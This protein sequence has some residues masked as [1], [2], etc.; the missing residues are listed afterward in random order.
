M[1][2]NV[3]KTNSVFRNSF[4]QH[5]S[6]YK[7]HPNDISKRAIDDEVVAQTACNS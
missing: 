1:K 5:I 7:D 6:G 2:N 3:T 4:R